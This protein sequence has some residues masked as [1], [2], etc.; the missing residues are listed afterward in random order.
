MEETTCPE[1]TETDKAYEAAESMKKIERL[2]RKKKESETE[3]I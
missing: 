3:T 2:W 1:E